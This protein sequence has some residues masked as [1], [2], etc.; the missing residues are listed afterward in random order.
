MADLRPFKNNSVDQAQLVGVSAIPPA[1][2][3]YLSQ[4]GNFVSNIGGA[5]FDSYQKGVENQKKDMKAKAVGSVSEQLASISQASETTP[6]YDFESNVRRLHQKAVAANPALAE[7]IGKL[8]EQQSGI[9]PAGESRVAIEARERTKEAEEA[10]AINQFMTDEERKMGEEAFFKNKTEMQTLNSK[11]EKIKTQKELGELGDVEAQEAVYGSLRNTV[12][13]NY[14]SLDNKVSSWRRRF[15]SGEDP[16]QLL[17]EIRQEKLRQGQLF[18]QFGTLATGETGTAMVKPNKDI[19]DF[20]ESY[21]TGAVDATA[22]EGKVKAT[23]ARANSVLYSDPETVAAIVT[24]EAFQF[25]PSAKLQVQTTAAKAKNRLTNTLIGLDS[26]TASDLNHIFGAMCLASDNPAAVEEG[27]E[28]IAS[29]VDEFDRNGGIMQPMDLN[30]AMTVLGTDEVWKTA[31][32]DTKQQAVDAFQLHMADDIAPAIRELTQKNG[33]AQYATLVTDGNGLRLQVLPEWSGQRQVQLSARTANKELAEYN[34]ALNMMMNATGQTMQEVVKQYFKIDVAPELQGPE[35]A[36]LG[37]RVLTAWDQLFGQP[38]VGVFQGNEQVRQERLAMSTSQALADV[39]DSA[40]QNIFGDSASAARIEAR[41]APAAPD[42]V[43]SA[44]TPTTSP[45][46]VQAQPEPQAEPFNA[47][48]ASEEEIRAEQERI[49][50]NPD[51]KWGPQSKRAQKFTE[52]AAPIAQEMGADLGLL[53]KMA[54]VE[55][56]FQPKAKAGTSSAG[57]YFQFI[58]S[59]WDSMLA[60]Y[61]EEVGVGLDADK[62][63]PVANTKMAIKLIEENAELL[64]RRT[65]QE[66]T[67]GNLYLAHFAGPATAVKALR[68]DPSAPASSVF[69]DGQIKSNKNVLQGKTVGEVLE[70]AESK[71]R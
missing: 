43:T 63:D 17:V 13:T 33:I 18:S 49:G 42:G 8:I 19:L 34:K 55:S 1:S 59:T 28:S 69:S 30:N 68:A 3:S 15:D 65:G 45:E 67:A 50:A 9:N 47:S 36:T 27:T 60:R 2:T 41:R 46:P 40:Q 23:R 51:G 54:R 70:W 10:G 24:S 31:S 5:A 6:G 26:Q 39:A 56:N 44:S 52:L 16:K 22:Y 35:E 32:A 11:L 38:S 37:D 58:D 48:T 20:A 62:T 57:G 4:A 64:Q 61:G 71:M 53:Q 14:E 29:L 25:S 12:N 7:D 21:V 66:P